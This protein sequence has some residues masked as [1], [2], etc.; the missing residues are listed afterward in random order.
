MARLVTRLEKR[1]ARHRHVRRKVHGTIERPRL[2]IFRSL[3]HIYVQVID[4]ET[5][6][7]LT[8]ASS[9]EPDVAALASGP[10]KKQ[11][12]HVVGTTVAQRAIKA[13]V[14]RGVLDR[15]GYKYHG[16]VKA[17]AEGAR[18]GGLDF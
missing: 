4:D 17:L 9:K 16:R 7:T 10:G 6:H 2:S 3:R 1:A 12:A 5:G 18:E 11:V 15:G 8:A 13:G 14:T